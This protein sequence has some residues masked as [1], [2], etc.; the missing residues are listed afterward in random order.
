MLYW[1]SRFRRKVNLALTG[2]PGRVNRIFEISGDGRGK[3]AERRTL[4]S[5]PLLY[6]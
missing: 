4:R 5:F 2:S 6:S 3:Q 1:T